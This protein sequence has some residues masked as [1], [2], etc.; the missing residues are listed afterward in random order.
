MTLEG[1]PRL[2]QHMEVL[3][4][5][6]TTVDDSSDLSTFRWDLVNAAG[7]DIPPPPV[8]MPPM[9]KGQKY[10]AQN[11]PVQSALKPTQGEL[12]SGG[13]RPASPP[14]HPLY[15]G[16]EYFGDNQPS[17]SSPNGPGSS[18]GFGL[19]QRP[20]GSSPDTRV[21]IGNSS[22][23][24]P[25]YGLSSNIREG[26]GRF[27]PSRQPFGSSPDARLVIGDSRQSKPAYGSSSNIREGPGG[28]V[29]SQQPY[30]SSYRS[31]ESSGGVGSYRQPST[32][33]YRPREASGRLDRGRES[34]ASSYSPLAS[35]GGPN[36]KQQQFR[37]SSNITGSAGGPA[38]ARPQSASSSYRPSMLQHASTPH[39]EA[40]PAF[41]VVVKSSPSKLFQRSGHAS[42]PIMEDSGD[43]QNFSSDAPSPAASNSSR[44]GRPPKGS[45]TTPR[46]TSSLTP[47]KR[48]RPFKSSPGIRFEEPVM[49][50]RGRP[51]S[52]P[53][54]AAKA[55]AASRSA[56]P[57]KRGRPFTIRHH[58]EVPVP[59]PIYIPFICEWKGCPAELQNLETLRMH[60]FNVHGKKSTSGFYTCLW[61]KCINPAEE[62]E[63]LEP[64][65]KVFEF[66]TKA[67]W[68]DHVEKAHVTTV[69][70]Y[71]GDGPKGSHFCMSP[72]LLGLIDV[73][74]K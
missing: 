70:W 46:D 37:R 29:S 63:D 16:V 49:K 18:A 53:H 26:S 19:N 35:Y 43:F 61:D 66:K 69:A 22:Q 27:D 6:F 57:K 38:Q 14:Y 9:V 44:R 10:A 25:A 55:A 65:K 42:D 13:I 41:V 28:V 12:L 36:L 67:T 74:T 48:G 40:G 62:M 21:V 71:L 30:V 56:E 52:T 33:S 17:A 39:S 8:S 11:P 58:V 50:K 1:V 51:F 59:D 15:G 60:L 68:K 47:K 45:V 23:S 72:I 5:R 73:L 31:G 64:D 24:K 54:A 3:K 4:D 34:Y 20:F 2:N 32:S 7:P